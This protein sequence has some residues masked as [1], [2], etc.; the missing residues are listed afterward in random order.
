MEIISSLL[1]NDIKNNFWSVSLIF[2]TFWEK[3]VGSI[4]FKLEVFSDDALLKVMSR[5]GEVVSTMNEKINH[6]SNMTNTHS[7]IIKLADV[8]SSIDKKMDEN[9][10]KPE[11]W[12]FISRIFLYAQTKYIYTR[13]PV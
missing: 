3:I 10:K 12:I 6:M 9:A 11:V 4:C 2:G 13:K 7:E 5:L 8:V 1:S